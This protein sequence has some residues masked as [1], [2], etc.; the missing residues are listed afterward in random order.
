MDKGDI[1]QLKNR[2]FVV[3]SVKA[4]HEDHTTFICTWAG[5]TYCVRTYNMD[6]QKALD[7]YKQLKHAGI[8]MAKMCYHDDDAKVIAFDYFPER[9]CL[10]VLSKNEL[11]DAYFT[12]LFDLYRFCRYSKVALD[13]EPQNFMLRGSQ[14]FY[15]PTKWEPLTDKNHLEKGKLRTWFLGEEGHELLKKKGFETAGLPMLKE[16][17]VNKAV[18]LTTVKNW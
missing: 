8:N 18:V 16:E 5:R 11:T 10:E 12:A 7:D 4:V 9:N 2:K 14:M 17:E 13:W 15:L 1:I 3:E 6:Y